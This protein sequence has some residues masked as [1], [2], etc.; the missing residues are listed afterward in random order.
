MLEP[1]IFLSL[2]GLLYLHL[3]SFQPLPPFSAIFRQ[4]VPASTYIRV[5][6]EREHGSR[7]RSTAEQRRL[8]RER[9]RERERNGAREK[10]GTKS[11]L[12]GG[13]ARRKG[14]KAN[15]KGVSRRVE[16][17]GRVQPPSSS[18]H[19]MNR[20]YFCG[21]LFLCGLVGYSSSHAHGPELG[22]WRGHHREPPTL[23]L[24]LF[25]FS[26]SFFFLLFFSFFFFLSYFFSFLYVKQTRPKRMN[27]ELACMR[28]ACFEKGL[29][30]KDK[31]RERNRR[32]EKLAAT[33]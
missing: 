2:P 20:V 26:L 12:G 4:R 22:Q 25:S 23:L 10:E 27:C 15:P 17:A 30:L 14:E 8:A 31:G 16:F 21:Q 7:Y 28:V 24:S 18:T 1:C 33:D 13:K 5:V 29:L 9:E 19:P 32:G 11:K 6:L 3:F